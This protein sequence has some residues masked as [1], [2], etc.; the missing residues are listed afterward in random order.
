[1]AGSGFNIFKVLSNDEINQ[2]FI[3]NPNLSLEFVVR[4]KRAT[5]ARLLE[6]NS[7][8]GEVIFH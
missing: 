1:M 3:F 5:K 2:T 6:R 7:R 8:G 4:G